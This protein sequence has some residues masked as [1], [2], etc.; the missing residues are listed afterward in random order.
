MNN[1]M[2]V[3]VKTWLKGKF[4]EQHLNIK[5]DPK[6]SLQPEESYYYQRN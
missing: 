3:H 2:R 4:L 5:M 1:F 6:P